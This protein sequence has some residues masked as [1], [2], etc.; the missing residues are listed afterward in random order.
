M[1]WRPR[2]RRGTIGSP[3]EILRPRQNSLNPHVMSSMMESRPAP[4][5]SQPSRWLQSRHTAKVM[6]LCPWSASCVG[7][8]PRAWLIC[9]STGTFRSRFVLRFLPSGTDEHLPSFA[10]L[11]M[12]PRLREH[13]KLAGHPCTV[14]GMVGESCEMPLI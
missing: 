8:Y 1:N 14:L 3:R 10:E 11:A 7:D 4:A 9:P 6:W 2:R 12:S 13:T 5:C